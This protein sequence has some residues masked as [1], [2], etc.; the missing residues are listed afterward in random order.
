M[1]GH[2]D[3]DVSDWELKDGMRGGYGR[4]PVISLVAAD[5]EGLAGHGRG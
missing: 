4:R 5:R 2:R 3:S 1:H